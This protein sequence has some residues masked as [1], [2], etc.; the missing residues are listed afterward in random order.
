MSISRFISRRPLTLDAL[1]LIE[2][3]LV[4]LEEAQSPRSTLKTIVGEQRAKENM[5]H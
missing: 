2:S 4:V 5:Y 3:E 1:V